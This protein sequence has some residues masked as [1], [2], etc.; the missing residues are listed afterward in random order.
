MIK[1]DWVQ[2]IIQGVIELHE[3]LFVQLLHNLVTQIENVNLQYF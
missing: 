2:L 3:S 1:K